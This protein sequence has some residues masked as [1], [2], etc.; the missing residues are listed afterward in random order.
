MFNYHDD[1]V[2]DMDDDYDLDAAADDTRDN[3]HERGIRDSDL[4]DE[5]YSRS[6]RSA[7]ILYFC[8]IL[9]H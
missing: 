6:V 2:E 1:H 5:K 8:A 3:H 7:V 9:F 4:E